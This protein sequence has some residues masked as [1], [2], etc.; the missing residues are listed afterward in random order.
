METILQI[1]VDEAILNDAESVAGYVNCTVTEL[2]HDYI[3]RLSKQVNCPKRP[4]TIN[5]KEEL[6]E[7]LDF[8]RKQYENGEV[9]TED[10]YY[11]LLD[12]L[13]DEKPPQSG[14]TLCSTMNSPT[15]PHAEGMGLI[16]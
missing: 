11:D 6:Y 10:E 12:D 4:A 1:K 9:L 3:L 15:H 8:A 5:T 14:R 7:A 13:S 16:E 2:V